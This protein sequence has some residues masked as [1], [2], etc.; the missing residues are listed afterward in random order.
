MLHSL[1]YDE[2]ASDRGSGSWV[3]TESALK[4]LR[5]VA[6]EIRQCHSTFTD[7]CR[8]DEARPASPLST[9]SSDRQ[10]TRGIS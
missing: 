3:W 2:S 7:L 5:S 4:L 8:V 6:V 10:N 9:G 1:S